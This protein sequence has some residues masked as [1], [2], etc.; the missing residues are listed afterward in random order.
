[1]VYS[2]MMNS[3][4]GTGR[5]MAPSRK[6]RTLGQAMTPGAPAPRFNPLALPVN[7]VMYYVTRHHYNYL[8]VQI[9]IRIVLVHIILGPGLEDDSP[10]L[11]RGR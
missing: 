11:T 4:E 8:K 9:L 6:G 2:D 1:M 3:R 7:R 5:S 10:L